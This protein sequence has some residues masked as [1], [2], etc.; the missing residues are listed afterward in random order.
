M[1]PDQALALLKEW[2]TF[3]VIIYGGLVT[4]CSLIVKIL[5]SYIQSVKEQ[6][7]EYKPGKFLVSVIALLGAIALNSPTS[8][9]IIADNKGK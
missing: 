3:A 7:P 1:T 5:G 8:A 2:G 4:G 6:N 9:K